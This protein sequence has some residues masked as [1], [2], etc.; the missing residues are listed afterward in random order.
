M[1]KTMSDVRCCTVELSF[2]RF[3][4]SLSCVLANACRGAL[5]PANHSAPSLIWANQNSIRVFNV[6][7]LYAT[8][9]SKETC[10]NMTK[11]LFV[12]VFILLKAN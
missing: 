6:Y 1:C 2:H 8:F 9:H 5:T 12:L 3:H 4:H 7:K 11:D 10:E